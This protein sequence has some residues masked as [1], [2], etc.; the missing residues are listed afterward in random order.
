MVLEE[1]KSSAQSRG[2]RALCPVPRRG[3]S[4]RRPWCPPSPGDST[5]GHPRPGSGLPG[6]S[7]DHGD[8]GPVSRGLPWA[9]QGT[10][11]HLKPLPSSSFPMKN[12]PRRAP[13]PG[14]YSLRDG[15]TDPSP[16]YPAGPTPH[17]GPNP[18]PPLSAPQHTPG[19]EKGT[20]LPQSRCSGKISP[21]PLSPTKPSGFLM[22][23]DPPPRKPLPAAAGPSGQDRPLLLRSPVAAP[24]SDPALSVV[25][26]LLGAWAFPDPRGAAFEEKGVPVQD[27]LHHFSPLHPAWNPAT[28]TD[29][30][31]RIPADTESLAGRPPGRG[32]GLIPGNAEI[33][34]ERRRGPLVAAAAPASSPAS[35][36]TPPSPLLIKDQL[37]A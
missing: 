5:S 15:S 35:H 21:P 37:E 4:G 1:G 18:R 8:Q 33:P 14:G 6:L 34:A 36:P 20:L 12:V 13:C 2:V 17:Q 29:T 10:G 23:R 16:V 31:P 11:K 28:P 22:T 9:L 19:E 27:R 25:R 24:R 26:E 3:E 32:A 7:T 30:S